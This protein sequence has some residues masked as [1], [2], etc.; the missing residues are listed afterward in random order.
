MKLITKA[1][2]DK[3]V[4]GGDKPALKLFSPVGAATWLISEIDE[5]GIMFGLCYLGHGSPELGYVS[6]DEIKSVRLPLGLKI[7]RD[8]HF[9]PD[10]TLTEYAKHARI[11]G[12]IVA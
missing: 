6:L 5:D 12:R 9:T 10:K 3:L 1:I 8:L 7:E 2:F 4:K 11:A